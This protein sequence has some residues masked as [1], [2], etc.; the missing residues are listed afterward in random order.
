MK[1]TVGKCMQ[2]S[3]LELVADILIGAHLLALKQQKWESP[4]FG[5][6]MI[7]SAQNWDPCMMGFLEA[8][9]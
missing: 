2:S 1:V 5:S 4:F 6:L 3:N 8:G 7:S 9:T